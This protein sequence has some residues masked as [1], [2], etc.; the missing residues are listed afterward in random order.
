MVERQLPKLSQSRPRVRIVPIVLETRQAKVP[1]DPGNVT[2]VPNGT[3][4]SDIF[5]N[6]SHAKNR[7]N[8]FI[9][10]YSFFRE[11]THRGLPMALSV[12][13]SRDG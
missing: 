7:P 3:N 8:T 1:G 9:G 6:A 2:N 5:S 13:L 12:S 4:A 11:R 10:V